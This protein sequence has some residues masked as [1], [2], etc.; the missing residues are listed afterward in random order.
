MKRRM[1]GK[2]VGRMSVVAVKV[3]VTVRELKEKLILVLTNS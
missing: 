3:K 2:G 1:V